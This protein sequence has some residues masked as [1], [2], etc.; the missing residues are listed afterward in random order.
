M[1][2]LLLRLDV[3][4]VCGLASDM[5][6]DVSFLVAGGRRSNPDA[7]VSHASRTAPQDGYTVCDA[8][9]LWDV[10]RP[11]RQGEFI[12]LSSQGK[13]YRKCLYRLYLLII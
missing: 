3:Q 7:R 12:S 1:E 2:G 4:R 8:G 10:P 9:R 13:T 11:S 6:L 5:T